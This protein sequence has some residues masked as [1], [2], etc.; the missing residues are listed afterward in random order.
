MHTVRSEVYRAVSNAAANVVGDADREVVAIN[1]R[2]YI[3]DRSD[4]P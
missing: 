1:E 4:E 3:N 2:H